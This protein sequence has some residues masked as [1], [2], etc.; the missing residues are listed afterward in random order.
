MLDK[1][2][3]NRPTAKKVLTSTII[4]K[5]LQKNMTFRAVGQTDQLN[6]D[7]VFRATDDYRFKD[8][9]LSSEISE[10]EEEEDLTSICTEKL[11]S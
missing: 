11:S 7:N 10:E 2:P 5:F 4:Q 8:E 6:E 3:E 1:D 9:Y